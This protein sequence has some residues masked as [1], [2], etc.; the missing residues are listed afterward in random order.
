VEALRS[1]PANRLQALVAERVRQ[2]GI[3]VN[4]RWRACFV[5]TDGGLDRIEVVDDR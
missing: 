1:P 2:F 4:D 3:R 5:W